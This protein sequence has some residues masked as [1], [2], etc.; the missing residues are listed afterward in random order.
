MDAG[1]LR[2]ETAADH[3]ELSCPAAP[4]LRLGGLRP[5]LHLDGV[6][7]LPVERAVRQE[8]GFLS[9]EYHFAGGAALHL[10]VAPL[11]GGLVLCPRLRAPQGGAVLNRV[12][13]LGADQVCLGQA[14]ARV[15]ILEQGRYWGK[16]TPLASV[17]AAGEAP[18]E[19]AGDTAAPARRVSELVWA[20]YDQDTRTGLL[21]G[22][23]SSERWLG[24]IE[25]E[26]TAVGQIRRWSLGFDGGDLQLAPGQELALEEVLLLAGPDPWQLLIDYAEEVRRRHH[27]RL[28]PDPPVSWCS[29]YPYR[30]SVSQE[31][32]VANAQVGARRLKPLG[33][34]IIEVDLGWERQYLP[35]A[36][37]ENGQFAQG[38]AW[39]AAQLR[40]LGFDLGIWKAPFT[41][42]A[43]DPVVAEH[44]EWL[45][46]D[47]QGQPAAYGDWFWEPYGK[48]YILDL[49]HP[50]AQ[51]WL[52]EK[53][54]YLHQSGV[55]YFKPDFIG[56]VSHGL[57]KHRHDPGMVAGGGTEAA[58]LGARVIRESL[59]DALV[60]NCGGPEMPGTGHFP[61]LYTCNDTGN[62]GF[63]TPEF[64]QA[65]HLAVACH[66]FKNRRWGILQ[67]SCLAVGLPGSIEDARLRATLAF[68]AGGQIDI[69]DD[70][71]T[72]P[73]ERWQV[74]EATLPPLGLSARPVDLFEPVREVAAFDYSPSFKAEALPA[75]EQPPA[76]V[77]H[78]HLEREWDSWELVGVFSYGH[79]DGEGRPRLSS[80]AIPYAQL[81]LDPQAQY[82]GYEFWSGLFL[83]ALGGGRVNQ[84]GYGHPGDF[85][86]LLAGSDPAQLGLAFFGPAAKLVCLRRTR[87]H[88]WVVGTSFH[89]S[90]G[91]ELRE[92]VW[93]GSRSALCGW[94]ERPVSGS[95]MVVLAT[96]E[97]VPAAAE[98]GGRPVPLRQGARG[99]WLLPVALD[100]GPARWQ[101]FFNE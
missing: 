57:A 2:L 76:S 98:V 15:R 61:L 43:H 69:S 63:I 59:P 25:L 3:L 92:V 82:W 48:I 24:Q 23:L 6:P 21:A 90:C 87:P 88:P 34:E 70:L 36:F 26:A 45:I 73:E 41:I 33:L 67:P 5:L 35:N 16:V 51:D 28:L 101:V 64:Q 96:G 80:F 81:G 39:L 66:L 93:D 52:R 83:G 18:A 95:G 14:P 47:G 1:Q 31:R 53:L 78:L 30:L 50:G 20:A 75:G 89:Q 19:A 12:E 71:T 91:A 54:A 68:L 42:S 4:A 84:E 7:L 17:V 11:H 46:G 8:E 97:R 29:W 60:L 40:E 58:R 44:P 65:N 38:L 74:L 100:Q 94:V 13:L 62:T 56:C 55:R 79:R 37:E 27:P 49:T 72:L 10:G 86:E 99:A 22:F 85:Q 77:W 32:V 9:L